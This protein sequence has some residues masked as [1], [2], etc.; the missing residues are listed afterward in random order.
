MI[1]SNKRRTIVVG[2]NEYEYAVKGRWKERTIFIKNST[3]KKTFERCYRVE[4]IKPFDVC[5]IILDEG[6]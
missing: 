3:T 2:G 1:P 4:Q 5:Q 6:V